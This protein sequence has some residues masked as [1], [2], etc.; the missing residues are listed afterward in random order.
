MKSRYV[1]PS[2]KMVGTHERMVWHLIQAKMFPQDRILKRLQVC[3]SLSFQHLRTHHVRMSSSLEAH[4]GEEMF[5]LFLN[6]PTFK[7]RNNSFQK[8]T[9]EP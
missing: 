1:S 7:Q 9:K 6:E 2:N 3:S 5:H 4:L 8:K